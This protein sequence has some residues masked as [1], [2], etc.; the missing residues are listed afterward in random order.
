MFQRNIPV[1][2]PSYLKSN[3]ASLHNIWMQLFFDIGYLGIFVTLTLLILSIKMVGKNLFRSDTPEFPAIIAF[4][5]A[6]ISI[7][8]MEAS[9]S[10]DYLELFILEL[11][12]LTGLA[13]ASLMKY[14]I[15]P[16]VGDE[17]EIK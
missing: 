10:P 14:R 3:L 17:N 4:F 9:I 2:F 16:V 15:M 5:L 6:V 13:A 11:F 12:M 8:S 7:G 1:F